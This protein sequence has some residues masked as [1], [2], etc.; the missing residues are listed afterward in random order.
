MYPGATGRNEI[1]GHEWMRESNISEQIFSF[2]T[3][4][5]NRKSPGTEG[6]YF[7]LVKYA[8]ALLHNGL[9]NFI[10]LCWT[11]RLADGKGIPHVQERKL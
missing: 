11:R 3:M 10:N 7:E 1:C 4:C 5:K 9:L 6:L 2:S 8:P